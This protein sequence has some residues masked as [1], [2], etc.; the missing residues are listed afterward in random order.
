MS[1]KQ[2]EDH[3]ECMKLK[4]GS[5]FKD[6]EQLKYFA[7]IPVSDRQ[8]GQ[9]MHNIQRCHQEDA[10]KARQQAKSTSMNIT[11]D[12]CVSVNKKRKA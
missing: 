5:Q 1:N 4:Y 7:M 3:L 2:F 6:M 9:L 11:M 8:R 12:D 10:D